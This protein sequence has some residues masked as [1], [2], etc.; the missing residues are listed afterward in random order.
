MRTVQ[1]YFRAFGLL[2]IEYRER[3]T[4]NLTQGAAVRLESCHSPH[5]LDRCYKKVGQRARIGLPS[6]FAAALSPPQRLG[7]NGLNF[8]LVVFQEPGDLF[9]INCALHVRTEQQAAARVVCDYNAV[10]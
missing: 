6:K 4:R 9:V 8:R 5:A 1:L 3:N 10:G 2:S 7:E